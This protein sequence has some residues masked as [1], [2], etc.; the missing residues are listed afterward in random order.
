MVTTEA[1]PIPWP[2]LLQFARVVPR[3]CPYVN[4]V[5]FAF[6][7]LVPGPLTE[8]VPTHLTRDVLATLR[9]ADDVVNRALMRH[10]LITTVSQVKHNRGGGKRGRKEKKASIE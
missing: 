7:P 2:A 5:V 9:E 8:I 4:R 10:N 6:G 1:S 3:A